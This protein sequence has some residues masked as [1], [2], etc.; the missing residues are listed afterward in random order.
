MDHATVRRRRGAKRQSSGIQDSTKPARK[1]SIF[2]PASCIFAAVLSL[3]FVYGY[4][5]SPFES[6][7]IWGIEFVSF[8]GKFEENDLLSK[9]IKYVC[10]SIVDAVSSQL[11]YILF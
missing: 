1:G 7:D 3:V 4:F 6:K 11:K 10:P 5:N 2:W 8:E 9:G